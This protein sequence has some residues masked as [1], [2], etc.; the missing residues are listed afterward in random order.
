MG[1]GNLGL[2][3]QVQGVGLLAQVAQ[4]QQRMADLSALLLWTTWHELTSKTHGWFNLNRYD[5]LCAT[6]SL[7]SP[8]KDK[9]KPVILRTKVGFGKKSHP[10][11]N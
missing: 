11:E 9:D 4:K 1:W 3:D 10:P 8:Q 7:L 6:P 5:H 2:I